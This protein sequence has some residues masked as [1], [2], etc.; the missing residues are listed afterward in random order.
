MALYAG[1]ARTASYGYFDR[2]EY[3]SGRFFIRHLLL[4][5]AAF[6]SLFFKNFPRFGFGCLPFGHKTAASATTKARIIA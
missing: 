2:L 4:K 3:D 5:F 6:T 1:N